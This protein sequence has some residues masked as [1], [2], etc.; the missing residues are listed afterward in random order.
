VTKQGSTKQ[1]L[2]LYAIAPDSDGRI[3][4]P[5]GLD[6]GTV[7]SITNGRVSAV[8]SDVPEKLRPERRQLAAHQEVLKRLMGET[9]GILPVVGGQMPAMGML[10]TAR[11][12]F[13]E[14]IRSEYKKW[15]DVVRRS[16]AKV[17]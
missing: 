12:H 4:G 14:L 17:D 10:D 7:Y 8:V 5:I 9:A 6:G 11:G 15:G 3:F 13:A 2:Y 16:G 1:K